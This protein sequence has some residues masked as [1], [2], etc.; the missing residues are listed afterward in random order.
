M[1]L[2]IFKNKMNETPNIVDPNQNFLKKQKIKKK[3]EQKKQQLVD[4]IISSN[5]FI[6][7]TLLSL[8]RS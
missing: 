5:V 8:K 2:S 4:K 7:W 1:I 3:H 6:S